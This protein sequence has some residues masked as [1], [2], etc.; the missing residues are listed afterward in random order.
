M[1]QDMIEHQ[2]NARLLAINTALFR[3]AREAIDAMLY[4]EGVSASVT[5]SNAEALIDFI[6]SRVR[7]LESAKGKR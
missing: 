4:D 2:T 1:T 6:K 7:K 5:A 3:Q